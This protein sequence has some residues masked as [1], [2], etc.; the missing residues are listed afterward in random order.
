LGKKCHNEGKQKLM[1]FELHWGNTKINSKKRNFCKKKKET[2][3]E[4]GREQDDSKGLSEETHEKKEKEEKMAKK[5][6]V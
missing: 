4:K 1:L 6:G 3:I 2:S 5:V